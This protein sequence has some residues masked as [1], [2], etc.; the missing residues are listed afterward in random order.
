MVL[1]AFYGNKK[2]MIVGD[3]QTAKDIVEALKAESFKNVISLE[4]PSSYAAYYGISEEK[5]VYTLFVEEAAQCKVKLTR[6]QGLL[7]DRL[8]HEVK[9]DYEESRK[10]QGFYKHHLKMIGIDPSSLVQWKFLSKKSKTFHGS[11]RTSLRCCTCLFQKKKA[12]HRRSVRLSKTILKS[13]VNCLW[14]NVIATTARCYPAL[15]GLSRT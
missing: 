4:A 13:K 11:I 6:V 14:Q 5:P 10:A 1:N 12:L 2:V 15:K 8:G 7:G 3:N 9:R